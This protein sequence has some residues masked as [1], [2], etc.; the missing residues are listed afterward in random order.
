MC[1]IDKIKECVRK[2]E[3]CRLLIKQYFQCIRFS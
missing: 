1:N 2:Q 3:D